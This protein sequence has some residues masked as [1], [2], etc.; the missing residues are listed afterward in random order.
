MKDIIVYLFNSSVYLKFFTKKVE[1]DNKENLQI[2]YFHHKTHFQE[3][4]YMGKIYKKYMKEK[5][6]KYMKENIRKY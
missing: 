2:V 4:A 6:E 1:E 5:Y 3:N